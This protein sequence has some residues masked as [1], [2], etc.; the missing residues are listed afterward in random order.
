MKSKL[1]KLK[2][3]W[4]RVY[5]YLTEF[6]RLIRAIN[7]T[8]EQRKGILNYYVWPSVQKEFMKLESDNPTKISLKDLTINES[9][10]LKELIIMK[11]LH[12]LLIEPTK[13][14]S[15]VTGPTQPSGNQLG[16][17]STSRLFWTRSIKTTLRKTYRRNRSQRKF[18]W[19][20]HCMTTL[21][22]CHRHHFSQR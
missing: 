1:L 21:R 3:D 4:G 20:R 15:V 7:C 18:S 14:K 6:N 2:H 22:K 10:K 12:K 9:I 5:D 8:E 16:E 13:N 17:S 19:A 11:W